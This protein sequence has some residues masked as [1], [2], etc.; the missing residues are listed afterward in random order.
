M[1][2][3]KSFLLFH[4]TYALAVTHHVILKQSKQLRQKNNHSYNDRGN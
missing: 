2:K 4:S 1:C 3:I